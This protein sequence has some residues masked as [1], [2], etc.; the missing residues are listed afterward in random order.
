[1]RTARQSVRATAHP[2]LQDLQ[3]QSLTERILRLLSHEVS[4]FPLGRIFPQLAGH[5]FL[6]SSGDTVLRSH[7]PSCITR[8]R[9]AAI[10]ISEVSESAQRS[11]QRCPAR[12]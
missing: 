4:S 1:M 11:A 10:A 7:S 2:N 8:R 5:L 3:L 9:A 12:H 6:V